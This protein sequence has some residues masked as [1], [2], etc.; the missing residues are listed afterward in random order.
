ML[1]CIG[2]HLLVDVALTTRGAARATA[3]LAST[4]A[5]TRATR[6]G[7]LMS[8]LPL[9][10]KGVPIP[11]GLE[12]GLHVPRSVDGSS[13]RRV[14]HNVGPDTGPDRLHPNVV[15]ISGLVDLHPTPEL[16]RAVPRP[17]PLPVPPTALP[18]HELP[19]KGQLHGDDPGPAQLVLGEDVD[20]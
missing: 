20:L 16:L 5:T 10:L 19:S 1:T 3:A 2:L 17:E 7:R 9:D 18:A 12:Q 4:K 13:I 11:P 14:V 6:T 15:E 8:A